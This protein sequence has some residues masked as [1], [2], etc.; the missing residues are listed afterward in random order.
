[1]S[2]I[3]KNDNLELIKLENTNKY[4]IQF[5]VNT[6]ENAALI[7][8]LVRT[9]IIQGATVTRDYL[10]LKFQAH[11]VETFFSNNKIQKI[12][13]P[14]V[15]NILQT[16]A[17][18]LNYLL[19]YES[20]T[21]IGY[22]PNQI[23]LINGETPAFLGSQL[24][25]ELDPEGENLATICCLFNTKEFFAAP[26]LLKINRLPAKVH[27]KSSYYSLAS[28]IIYLLIYNQDN[29]HTFDNNPL[30]YLDKHP[31]KNTKLYWLLSRCL[32]EDP[33]KRS[34]IFI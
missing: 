8:S 12:K 9:R 17:N 30:S 26:E 2:T 20:K 4:I 5:R 13:I 19:K 15:A 3:F 18:Q 29:P 32:E 33:N 34:I 31:I 22:A 25:A 23:I 11:S 21:I 16:L 1:M 7:R 10:T 6:H 14:E 28:L 24:I 27:Y